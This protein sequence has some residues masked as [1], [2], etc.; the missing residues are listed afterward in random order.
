MLREKRQ[1]EKHK[2]TLPFQSFA[3]NVYSQNGEDGILREILGKV[4]N[5]DKTNWC[6]E[7]GAWDG[8]HLSNTYNLVENHGYKA[9]YIESEKERYEALL[10]TSSQQPS[11]HPIQAVV[12]HNAGGDSSLDNLLLDTDLPVDFEVLSIDIDSHDLDIWE[13]LENYLPKIVVIEINSC[14]P[15]GVI[16]RHGPT[17]PGNTFSA[18]LKV[19]Q[20]KGYTLLCH[21]GNLVFIRSDLLPKLDFEPRFVEYPELL[22]IH[23]PDWGTAR[24]FRMGLLSRF[25]NKIRHF[26]FHNQKTE[27]R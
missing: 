11:I 19:A 24:P 26:L 25:K 15:P 5:L 23:D 20:A 16:W 22:F 2:M 3:S 1:F 9:V 12:D 7:F 13:T 4:S 27:L 21:T 18:V 17:T 8:K 6:V 14:V 10:L